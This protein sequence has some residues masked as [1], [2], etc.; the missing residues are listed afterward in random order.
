MICLITELQ[1]YSNNDIYKEIFQIQDA[2]K[3]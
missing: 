3:Q 2:L 1:K